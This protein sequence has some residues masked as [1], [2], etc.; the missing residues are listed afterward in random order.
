MSALLLGAAACQE[1]TLSLRGLT[2]VA[3]AMLLLPAGWH[4]GAKQA[5]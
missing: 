2:R 1:Q 4:R 5:T 3:G